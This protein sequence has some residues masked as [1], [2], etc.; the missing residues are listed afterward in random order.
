M[1]LSSSFNAEDSAGVAVG[2]LGLLTGVAPVAT[3]PLGVLVPLLVAGSLFV[4][5]TGGLLT[6]LT[7]RR[8]RQCAG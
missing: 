8:R 2:S 4:V 3:Q 7:R 1:R 5:A 6:V